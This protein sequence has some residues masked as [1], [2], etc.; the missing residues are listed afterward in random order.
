MSNPEEVYVYLRPTKLV[1]PKKAMEIYQRCA[2]VMGASA[3]E[4][5]E[6]LKA[7]LLIEIK[8]NVNS[9]TGS[10]IV[11]RAVPP[12]EALSETTRLILIQILRKAMMDTYPEFRDEHATH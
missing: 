8:G 11:L 7:N 9:K 3:Q 12:S 2:D 1:S 4:F 5:H 10:T 6:A